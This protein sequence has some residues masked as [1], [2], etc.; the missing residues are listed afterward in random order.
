L[1][2]TEVD[3]LRFELGAVEV[4][5]NYDRFLALAKSMEVALIKPQAVR[6]PGITISTDRRLYSE[7]QWAKSDLNPQPNEALR[8]MAPSAWLMAA[9]SGPNPLQS[10]TQWRDGAMQ[11]YDVPLWT[12]LASLMETQSPAS[13]TS[14]TRDLLS[15]MEVASNYNDFASLSA[16]DVLRRDALRRAAGPN[17]GTLAVAGG[18]QALPLA[19]AK[20]L[21]RPMMH[22]EMTRIVQTGQA[23]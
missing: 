1:E 7:A 22:A 15:M 8:A 13:K 11:P 4:G 19:M 16:L 18:S 2:T 14:E 6:I 20:A 5:E 21:K 12:Y 9:L 3:G 10:P 23:F 17:I